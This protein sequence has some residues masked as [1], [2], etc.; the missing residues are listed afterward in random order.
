MMV[1]LESGICVTSDSMRREQRM[2]VLREA[3]KL[4]VGPLQEGEL[5][6]FIVKTRELV[7]WKWVRLLVSYCYNTPKGED[8]LSVRHGIAVRRS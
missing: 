7:E 5:K 1:L 8:I 3:M 4:V 2:R 6:G